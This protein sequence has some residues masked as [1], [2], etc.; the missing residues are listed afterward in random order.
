[1][2]R[3]QRAD[4]LR[5]IVKQAVAAYSLR[6]VGELAGLTHSGVQKFLDGAVPYEASLDGLQRVADEFRKDD[7]E[8]TAWEKAGGM[9]DNEQNDPTIPKLLGEVR[10]NGGIETVE[11][12]KRLVL[13]DLLRAH[14]R[15]RRATGQDPASLERALAQL[16]YEEPSAFGGGIAGPTFFDTEAEAALERAR[17]ANRYWTVQQ[18]EAE[19]MR[20][21]RL[22]RI[23]SLPA[24]MQAAIESAR[25]LQQDGAT[26]ETGTAPPVSKDDASES[27]PP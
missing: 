4:A 5:P 12:E 18:I 17:A 3:R 14:I 9:A 22:L 25:A 27:T 15:L 13:I 10:H 19:E 21:R 11:G 16:G 2:T 24:D 1:M 7:D 26:S 6:Y 8:F 23:S 20:E